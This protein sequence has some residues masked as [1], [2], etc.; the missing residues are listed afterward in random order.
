METKDVLPIVIVVILAL[1]L[2]IFL[3]RKNRKDKKYLDP[4]AANKVGETRMD[5]EHNRES[6]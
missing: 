4:D 6:T 3:I 5:K 2:V 1:A